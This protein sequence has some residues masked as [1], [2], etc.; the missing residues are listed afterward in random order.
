MDLVPSR[1]SRHPVIA[2][3]G[4]LDLDA[5][6][7]SPPAPIAEPGDVIINTRGVPGT[8]CSFG[9]TVHG[10]RPVFLSAHHVLFGNNSAEGERVQAIGRSGWRHLG[11][12][13][14]GRRTSITYQGGDYHVD[15]AI[16]S[17]DDLPDET[18]KRL[19]PLPHPRHS[20]HAGDK[21]FKRGGASGFTAGTIIATS[22]VEQVQI[23]GRWRAAP[24]Q[25]LVRSIDAQ[26]FSSSGD[27]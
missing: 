9:L 19:T 25:I 8:L 5:R 27:S 24:G 21:V 23:R 1:T 22:A 6:A 14:Y 15:C 13:L 17:L 4:G 3:R 18:L 20:P 7:S 26:A 12:V 10:R 16:G 11:R 2:G